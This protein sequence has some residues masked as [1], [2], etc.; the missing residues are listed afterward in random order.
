VSGAGAAAERAVRA[1]KTWRTVEPVHGMIYF[2][3]EAA[4]AYA[5]L[6]IRGRSGYFASRAA[7]MGAV[8]AEVVVSTFFNFNPELVHRAIPAA[9][10]ITSPAALV[11]ARLDAAD[12]AFRR[13]LGDAAVGSAEMRRAAVLARAAAEEA[14][15][16]TEGRPLAAGHADLAWPEAPHLVLWH[17]QSVL[18]EYRGDGHIA[19]LVTHGLSGL[20][21][22]VTH[23]AAGDVPV[24]VLKATRAWSDEA[25]D[26]AVEALRGRGWLEPGDTLRFTA[27]GAGQRQAVEDGTDALAAEPYDALGEERC[28][29]LRA[30]VRPW[31]TEFAHLFR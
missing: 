14:A 13:V 25:W 22:L 8:S 31:S 18:R 5:R 11:A 15:Q 24:P 7:P 16:R 23:A 26:D 21:A 19:Q 3:P 30:L 2:A 10:E 29:E 17:A 9:W 12:A 4:E 20:E 1:R 6:G 27:R 28:T